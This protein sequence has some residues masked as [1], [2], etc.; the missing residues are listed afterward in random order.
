M[1][2]ADG[3]IR[4]H[5]ERPDEVVQVSSDEDGV[6]TAWV[7]GVDAEVLPIADQV[8]VPDDPAPTFF[9]EP[10]A[11]ELIDSGTLEPQTTS[12]RRDQLS[13]I[14]Y[15]GGNYSDT[16]LLREYYDSD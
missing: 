8:I 16:G 9:S 5:F 3:S 15:R 2:G 14:R 13:P 12:N 11:A 7:E 4:G 1:I 6:I 10:R